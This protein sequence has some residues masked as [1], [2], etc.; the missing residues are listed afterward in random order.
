MASTREL[1]GR[2]QYR[3]Q[4]ACRACGDHR[5]MFFLHPA[6]GGGYNCS[7]CSTPHEE[8]HNEHSIPRAR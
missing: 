8:H 7:K 4:Y 3:W 6:T 1:P 2:D 5:P